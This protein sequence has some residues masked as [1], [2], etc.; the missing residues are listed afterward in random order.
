MEK[1]TTKIIETIAKEILLPSEFEQYK[2]GSDL[3][4]VQWEDILRMAFYLGY[5]VRDKLLKL[6][7]ELSRS[8]LSVSVDFPNL[9]EYQKTLRMLDHSHKVLGNT[10]DYHEN[11]MVQLENLK[12]ELIAL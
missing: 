3:L 8:Q 11:F 12:A 7:Q 1:L 4:L 5:Q 2:Q 9:E 10:T 6:N